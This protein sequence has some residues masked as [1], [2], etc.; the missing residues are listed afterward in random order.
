[1]CCSFV[2]DVAGIRHVFNFSDNIT[3]YKIILNYFV[4]VLLDSSTKRKEMPEILLP[5]FSFF[6]LFYFFLLNAMSFSVSRI[7]DIFLAQNCSTLKTHART[8]THTHTHYYYYYYYAFISCTY[9]R[10][11]FTTHSRARGRRG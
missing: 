10:S 11:A 6:F 8:R 7:S 9:T 3:T 1:M 5:F 2:C 4:S